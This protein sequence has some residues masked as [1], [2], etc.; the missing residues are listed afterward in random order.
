MTAA[1]AFQT[2]TGQKA[3]ERDV[4]EHR[5]CGLLARR[6][7]GKTTIAGRIALRRMMK[8]PGET[9]VFG[10]VKVDLG[11]DMVREEAK[12]LRA[13][14]LRIAGG[15]RVAF[16]SGGNELPVNISEDDFAELYEATR[17]EFRLHHDRT[18]YSRTV[19][20]ALTPDCVGLGG[21]LIMDEVGRVRRFGEVLEAVMPIIQ[22][23]AS[24]RCIYTTTP[25][26]DDTHPSFALLAPPVGAEMPVRPEGN[27]YK[28][29]LGI[30]VRRVTVF[31]AE[32]DGIPLYDDDTGAV[33][34]ADESRRRDNNKDAWDRNFGCKF[35][36]GG[37]S[38]C[39]LLEIDNAQRKGMGKSFCEIVNDDLAFAAAT[40]RLESLLANSSGIVGGGWDLASTE[41]DTS[42]PSAFTV[43]EFLGGEFITR[44]SLLWKTSS[45]AIQLERARRI[46]AAVARRKSGVK[47][48]RL[49]ID[50]TGDRLFAKTM[51]TELS[52]EG[53]PVELVVASETVV[54][55]GYD[56]PVTRKTALGDKYVAA[57]NDNRHAFPPERYFRED[58][59]M[60]KKIRGSYVTDPASD[61]KHGDTFDAGKLAQEAIT[62]HAATFDFEPL[63]VA[64]G[65]PHW[66]EDYAE[67]GRA[68]L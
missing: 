36:I 54:M 29:E 43:M 23:N 51:Q 1:P 45:P 65:D 14:F 15:S 6:R 4:R 20:V 68:A 50:A 22:D 38:V 31:D 37:T 55:P 11:R 17:L 62:A 13:A 25:P 21:F 53:V 52:R 26:P 5:V 66:D 32:A 39:G 12:Q 40:A 42:N 27:T 33:I 41:K 35:V 30:F 57:L 46:L 58:H 44:A 3:F 9:I 64:G 10:S 24:L 63:A 48:R 18:T 61:G 60:P 47:M 28:S 19:I 59:R 49:C 67:T 16:A 8:V 56:S 34:S 7:Y 2:R